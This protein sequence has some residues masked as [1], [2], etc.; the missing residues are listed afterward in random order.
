MYTDVLELGV[1]KFQHSASKLRCALE[2]KK[3]CPVLPLLS[4]QRHIQ[5][6]GQGAH[7]G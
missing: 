2:E 1:L 6:Q 3:T 5:G 4:A 7:I